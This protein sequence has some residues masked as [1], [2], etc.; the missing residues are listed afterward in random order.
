EKLAYARLKALLAG[1]GADVRLAIVDACRSGAGLREKGGRPADAFTI[2]LADTLQATGEAF[3]TSSAADEAALESNEVM[4]SYFTHNFI[5]GLRGAADASGDKLVTLAEA[6]RYAYDRTVSATAML[7][8]GAQHPNYDYRLSGQGELVLATLLKPSAALVLPP[9]ERALVIDLARDQVLVE[10]PAGPAREVA[11]APG[12]YGVRVFKGGQAFGGR[13]RLTQGMSFTVHLDDLSPVTSSVLVAAKGGPV[14]VQ[15]VD[16]PPASKKLGL[17][18]AVGGTGRIL[19]A[20]SD[21]NGPK[22]QLRVTFEPLT[23]RFGAAGPVSFSGTLHLLG[24]GEM[25]FDGAPAGQEAANEAG[26]QLRVGYRASATWWRLELGLGVEAGLGFLSQ[27]YGSR[28][29]SLAL[30]GAPRL[31]LRGRVTDSVALT[32]DG[33]LTFT[34]VTI[35]DEAGTRLQWYAFPSLAVGVAFFF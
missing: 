32:V 6:Y 1:T 35:A 16:Q 11:L 4:G 18:V 7:P 12:D 33:D 25:S 17:G 21:T 13:V 23:T 27:L 10:V 29:S 22:W 9:A 19:A 15:T 3:I 5:S 34:G 20:P 28:A 2:R 30:A 24:L 14:V 26:A 31:F 8:V